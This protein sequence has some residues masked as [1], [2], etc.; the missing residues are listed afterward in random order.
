M[1]ESITK[2][3]EGGCKLDAVIPIFCVIGNK[4][5]RFHPTTITFDEECTLISLQRIAE[6]FKNVVGLDLHIHIVS[7]VLFYIRPLG[8]DPT[9]SSF[10]YKKLCDYIA[11]KKLDQ[12]TI[13]DMSLLPSG[14]LNEF[15]NE[16]LRAYETLMENPGAGLEAGSYQSWLRS[17]ASMITTRNIS[18]NYEEIEQTFRNHD[19]S[20]AFG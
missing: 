15:D 10:Y 17:M 7:D 12:L 20:T 5:K 6:N 16:Y 2:A 11:S 14:R 1:Q 19:F 3:L 4:L 8:A 9:V 13:H 18:A